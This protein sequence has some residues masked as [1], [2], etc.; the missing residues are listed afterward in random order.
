MKEIALKEYELPHR[1]TI[2]RNIPKVKDD[3]KRELFSILSN[4]NSL[5]V[6]S[7]GWSNSQLQHYL[8]L[9]AHFIDDNFSKK[10][11]SLILIP[12]DID[13][14]HISYA[15]TIATEF[16]TWGLLAKLH[17][18]VSDKAR[19]GCFEELNLESHSCMAHNVKM[20]ISNYVTGFCQNNA[21]KI[22]QCQEFQNLS[23]KIEKFIYILT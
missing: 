8:S 5:V 7:D 22:P 10:T 13:H 15:K 23:K 21:I 18:A 19:V 16:Q 9:S 14:S 12:Y 20:V 1:T 17:Y 11:I 2:S 6:T 3:L 4:S